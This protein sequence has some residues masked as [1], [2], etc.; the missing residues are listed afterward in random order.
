LNNGGYGSIYNMQKTRFDGNF[1]ACNADS[2][3]VLPDICRLAE[4]YGLKNV[5]IE[6]P[7]GLKT[8]VLEVL[9]MEGPVICDV[10]VDTEIPTAPRLSSEVMPDGRIV[11]KPMEDLWPFL[12]RAEFDEIMSVW[13]L[14]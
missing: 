14:Y 2:G 5:R 11:S 1:V 6:N 10:L 9:G 7:Q 12:A 13:K 4:A 8:K 3:L